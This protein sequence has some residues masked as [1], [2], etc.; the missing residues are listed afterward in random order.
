MTNNIKKYQYSEIFGNT[1]QG[2]GKFTGVPTVWVRFWG[3]NLNCNGF[4]QTDPTNPATWILDHQTIDISNI[5]KMEDL[6]VFNLGCDSGYS[7][8]K[9]FA[10]LAKT[11]TA[12]DI[13]DS[14]QELLRNEHN[15]DGLFLHPKSG[16][17]THLAFTGGEPMLSQNGMLEILQEFDRRGRAPRNITVETNGTQKLREPLR[18]YIDHKTL[19]D[20]GTGQ[21]EW[22]WSISPKLYLSGE[23]KVDTLKP[24]IVADYASVSKVGQLKYVSDGTDRSWLEVDE[25]TEAY[26]NKDVNFPIWIMPV[27]ATK[28]GQELIQASVAEGAIARGYNVAARVHCWIWGN[29]IGK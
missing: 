21:F 25:F 27:S 18:A 10:H 2:E 28:A 7:W 11:G 19:D 16:Q 29:I 1:I 13:C 15:P 24:Q 3:C 26:R 9:K 17:W 5:T 20:N 23:K 6:P 22:F 4:S 8:S 14:I 12:S